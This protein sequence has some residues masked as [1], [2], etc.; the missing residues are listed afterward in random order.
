MDG[1]DLETEQE[2]EEEWERVLA[3]VAEV[4]ELTPEE[5]AVGVSAARK[6]R[7][8]CHYPQA[9]LT[10][11]QVLRL[12]RR[13]YNNGFMQD[14][15]KDICEQKGMKVELMVRAVVTRWISILPVFQRAIYLEG[16][17]RELVHE[18]LFNKDKKRKLSK[19]EL[20]P[21]EIRVLKEVT[22]LLEVCIPYG[23]NARLLIEISSSP[24]S[25]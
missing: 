21:V 2:E 18:D 12:G 14:R 8:A 22:S 17:L 3:E 4:Q 11:A 16:P 23:D 24:S 6:V 13:V 15:L 20:T 19:Y 10:T 5:L 1:V 7:C 9:Q 25:P